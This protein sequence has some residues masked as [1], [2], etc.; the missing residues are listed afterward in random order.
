M[1]R[2]IFNRS[3]KTGREEP[4]GRK[5]V[6]PIRWTDKRGHVITADGTVWMVRDVTRMPQLWRSNAEQ[7]S[8]AEQLAKTLADIGLTSKSSHLPGMTVNR[9]RRIALLVHS[10]Y[11]EVDA[12]P[13]DTPALAAFKRDLYRTA[14][15]G[16]LV[17]KRRSVLVGVMLRPAAIK[18]VARQVYEYF[19]AGVRRALSASEQVLEL[20]RD[21]SREMEDI[22]AR[23]E[24]SIPTKE[25]LH[26]IDA[27]Y[28]GGRN[29]D[30]EIIEYNDRLIIGDD[31]IEVIAVQHF[32]T[33]RMSSTQ[34]WIGEILN[35]PEGPMCLAAF[36][37]LE[38]A[39]KA[40]AR[41]RKAA[42]RTRRQ[43]ETGAEIGD[44]ERGE[45][46]NQYQAAKEL[47]D[48]FLGRSEPWVTQASIII[49]RRRPQT[50][51]TFIEKAH[52][53]HGIDFLSLNGSQHLGLT[54]TVLGPRHANPYQQDLSISH[55]ANSGIIGHESLGD[56]TGAD[57][58]F[59]IEGD[60]VHI[61]P[62]RGGKLSRPPI[63][64]VFATTGS[65]KTFLLQMLAVQF[66]LAGWFTPFVNPKAGS[67]LSPM[68][69]LVPGGRYSNLTD[70]VGRGKTG[71]L[72]P[73]SFTPDPERAATIL[74]DF[75]L[76]FLHGLFGSGTSDHPYYFALRYRVS[77]GLKV[78]AL[79]GA[80]CGWEADLR[81]RID[82]HP[83]ADRPRRHQRVRPH[84]PGIRRSAHHRHP[85]P[86]RPPQRRRRRQ[87]VPR[88]NPD[89]PAQDPRGTGRR[90]QVHGPRHRQ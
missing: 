10:W 77:N 13:D 21:D 76:T 88:P 6:T 58:G 89:R 64:P 22:F 27:W 90:R 75:V 54:E 84:L 16:V 63:M 20:Y 73:F 2:S 24:M 79:G 56:P 71:A 32:D 35:N 70:L 11:A 66:A 42:R 86:V 12:D 5:W 72:D 46:A 82:H 85:I 61:N 57:M 55:L 47:E 44:E 28:N 34:R 49:A 68:V 31:T 67:D 80:R 7:I 29:P 1:D 3:I 50:S 4:D 23:H 53:A 9:Y 65:G 60:P 69:D 25:Q 38:P 14:D 83:L 81:R 74:S 37:T 41:A 78:A 17:A 30:V 18:N 40:R 15:G 26:W 87:R 33:E 43:A 19:N 39:D 62:G 59:S 36:G 51:T 48:F 45:H 52:T 8:D